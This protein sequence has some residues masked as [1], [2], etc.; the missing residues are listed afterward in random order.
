MT[1]IAKPCRVGQQP[2]PSPRRER[3]RHSGAGAAPRPSA[4]SRSPAQGGRGRPPGWWEKGDRKLPR[5]AGSAAC[6]RPGRSVASLGGA[7]ASGLGGSRARGWAVG[8]SGERRRE[9]KAGPG[10]PGR[11][12][13]LGSLVRGR[14]R[15]RGRGPQ[16]LASVQLRRDVPFVRARSRPPPFAR[17]AAV[18]TVSEGRG[19]APAGRDP[20]PAATREPMRPPRERGASPRTRTVPPIRAGF[21][22]PRDVR[23]PLSGPHP[24]PFDTPGAPFLCAC[25]TRTLSPGPL[26]RGLGREE[27]GRPCAEAPQIQNLGLRGP[28]RTLGAGGAS[29]SQET[30]FGVWLPK[31]LL[32]EF[33]TLRF[34][35]DL[36]SLL[37]C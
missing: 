32:A 14:R 1:A 9:G 22:R 28:A 21:L 30:A 3:H 11:C 31:V 23:H 29:V 8:P 7:E 12:C 19:L 26:P 15:C 33:H 27:G 18:S 36:P 35:I 20:F 17:E 10:R 6:A 25:H 37:L 5:A 16:G 13:A 34:S 4:E 2:E 24:H